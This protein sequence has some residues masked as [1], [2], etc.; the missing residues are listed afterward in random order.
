MN[1]IKS[2]FIKYKIPLIIVLLVWFFISVVEF[3]AI[4]PLR[5]YN[6]E[7]KEQIKIRAK[8]N[9]SLRMKIRQDSID[10]SE[11]DK[12]IKAFD[13]LEI[14]YKELINKNK[15]DYEKQKNNYN[16]RPVN[17]RRRIFSKLANE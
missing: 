14:H 17:E 12:K 5:S 8:E 11:K 3:L 4:S 13:S 15:L 7:L 1:Q 10:L 2:F 6:K 9:L 16:N